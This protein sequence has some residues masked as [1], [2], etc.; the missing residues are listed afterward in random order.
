VVGFEEERRRSGCGFGR[1]LKAGRTG[2][3]W[4]GLRIEGFRVSGGRLQIKWVEVDD[5]D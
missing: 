5:C 4:L 1:G 2:R 3:E